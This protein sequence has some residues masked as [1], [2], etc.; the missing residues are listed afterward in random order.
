MAS[1]I[2]TE[3]FDFLDESCRQ[4]SIGY[5]RNKINNQIVS[6]DNEVKRKIQRFGI[7]VYDLIEIASKDQCRSNVWSTMSKENF[8]SYSELSI[9]VRTPFDNARKELSV[10]IADKQWLLEDIQILNFKM[11]NSNNDSYAK[12]MNANTVKTGIYNNN[13]D[14]IPIS[15][16]L[17]L[18]RIVNIMIRF[19]KV[20]KTIKNNGGLSDRMLQ[21]KQ[22]S[23]MK[24]LDTQ[25]IAIKE[26][27][28]ITMFAV[29]KY[30]ERKF[31]TTH[32]H[33]KNR[34]DQIKKCYENVKND[35]LKLM[36]KIHIKEE[37]LEDLYRAEF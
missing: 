15:P 24:K 11:N 34:D 5:K 1:T 20:V 22:N 31:G 30:V 12:K 29:F 32:A 25:M 28:G 17:P 35:V 19:E 2:I 10:L 36:E 14:I 23:E 33:W 16:K 7:E 3:S 4:V 21:T 27:F 6:L 18:K 37:A 26:Q 8:C 13:D 9:D